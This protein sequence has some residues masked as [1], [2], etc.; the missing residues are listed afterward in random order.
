MKRYDNFFKKNNLFKRDNLLKHDRHR[1]AARN[2]PSKARSGRSGFTL[3]EILVAL[4]VLSLTLMSIYQSFAN[5]VFIHQATQGLWKAMVFTG[6]ELA[7]LER[8]PTLQVEVR[9]GEYPES[10]PMAGFRWLREVADEEP[11]PGVR[12]RKVIF[13]LSWGTATG[14]QTYRSQTYVPI[15]K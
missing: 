3:M 1:T 10:H 7:K 8:G 15:P 6:G 11:F 5:T 4:T 2:G 13:E 9:Q 12:V 14:R